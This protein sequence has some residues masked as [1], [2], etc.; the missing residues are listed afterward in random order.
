MK[1]SA[2]SLGVL[3]AFCGLFCC[4]G[5]GA[6]SEVG[7]VPERASVPERYRWDL[8]AIYPT[9]DDWEVHARAHPPMDSG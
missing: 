1:C 7:A 9:L 3:A 6:A 5:R 2:V 4:S 8:E